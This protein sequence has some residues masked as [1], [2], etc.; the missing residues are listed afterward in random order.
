MVDT[1]NDLDNLI[2]EI[3]NESHTGST[4]WQYHM[5]D[6]IRSYEATKPKQHPIGMT[7]I[8]PGG[9]NEELLSSPA[10]WVSFNGSLDDPAVTDGSKVVIAD[11]DHLCGICGDRGWAWKSFTRGENP[12][13]MDPYIDV[14][15]S[16]DIPLDTPQFVS[17]RENLGYIRT[18]SQRVDLSRA[19][20]CGALS[21]S[22]NCLGYKSDSQAEFLVYFPSAEQVSIDLSVANYELDVE[23]LNPVDGSLQSGCTVLGGSSEQNF[24]PPWPSEDVLYLYKK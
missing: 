5:I 2:Y 9:T 23:W 22:A 21:T 7:A 1:L 12:I 18:A 4:A 14:Y 17:L 20:P 24:Q 11:T 16:I 10:D 8:W 13:F 15:E 6:F 19:V 3:S